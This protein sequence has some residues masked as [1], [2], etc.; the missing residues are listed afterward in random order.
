MG[1]ADIAASVDCAVLGTVT[2][3]VGLGVDATVL[4]YSTV[5]DDALME[6]ELV[7]CLTGMPVELSAVVTPSWEAVIYT[8]LLVEIELVAMIV[9]CWVVVY[10]LV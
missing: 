10:K 1:V 9:F 4:K 7:V 3:Y 5:T 6:P 8:E 2:G